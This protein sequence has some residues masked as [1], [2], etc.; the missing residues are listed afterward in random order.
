MAAI[1][2]LI[3][4]HR[5]EH[6]ESMANRLSHRG[7]TRQLENVNERVSVGA[8]GGDPG[9]MIYRTET[10]MTVAS[11]RLYGLRDEP[12]DA[13][14]HNPAELLHRRFSSQGVAGIAGI[15]ADFA[16]V[17][18]AADASQVIFLRDFFGCRP[19]FWSVLN[20][21]CI[22]FASEY[23][24]ILALGR[25][26]PSVDRSMLQSLQ[27]TKR[28][29]VGRTLL[30]NV[31][32]VTPG[33]TM[34]EQG[35]IVAVEPYEALLADVRIH[36][37]ETAKKLIS[38][39]FREATR[40]RAG[41]SGPI[42][43]ALSGGIDSISLAF[44]L[45]DMFPDREIH[46]FSAGYD[47][48]DPEVITASQVARQI[49]AVHHPV[50]TPPSL[51]LSSL[52]KLV[53]HMEDPTSR[54]EAL[55]LM[56][57]GEVASGY[58]NV[59]LSGQGADGLFAGMPRHR[60]VGMIER[61]PLARGALFEILD[62]T[63]SGIQPQ[64]LLGKALALMLHRGHIPITPTVLE[65]DPIARPERIKPGR[66]FLN[67]MLA[68]T[69]QGST[70]QDIGKFERTFGA[71]GVQ[72]ASPFLDV[73]FA[74]AAFTIDERLKLKKSTDKYILRNAVS[75]VVPQEYRFR[76]KHPQRMR[77][78]SDFA[79]CLDQAADEFLSPAAV[80]SRRFF[81]P[82]SIDRLR[83]RDRAK[84][85]AAEPAM[86]LWTAITT[87]IWARLFVDNEPL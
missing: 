1:I 84:P 38:T 87:E 58:V 9:R 42:G 67:R 31:R 10:S 50:H 37:E 71:S 56:R 49:K 74:Q 76:R 78:D 22:A 46:T 55:Q 28:L 11:A 6:L 21:G 64:S 59:L 81:T 77:Y 15:D 41:T 60:L 70:F 7:A 33:A 26:R 57:I 65:A 32:S 72:Y 82:E 68:A 27:A 83:R 13:G 75:P 43:L 4:P 61:L 36:D 30:A 48:S 40:R 63:Q 8:I 29:P 45:R 18:C 86:Q 80:R 34:V 23:K 62:L 19:L 39:G 47:D 2:G 66:D 79:A 85:Y 3:G 16:A 5:P 20:D 14:W 53:W 52:K 73:A 17:I 44:H 69:Y 25:F 51:V 12:P 24:A 54:S 35:S